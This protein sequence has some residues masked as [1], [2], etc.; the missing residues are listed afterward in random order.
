MFLH[1]VVCINTKTSGDF[2]VAFTSFIHSLSSVCCVNDINRK[3]LLF[4]I[5]DGILC[6]VELYLV[7]FLLTLQV[8]CFYIYVTN[9]ESLTKAV[10]KIY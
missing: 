8:V 1:F 6:W 9:L 7:M 3:C 2:V 5:S 10:F 4:D